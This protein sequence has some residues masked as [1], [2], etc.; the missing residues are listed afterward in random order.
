MHLSRGENNMIDLKLV[1]P[2]KEYQIEYLDMIEE[3]KATGEKMVPF[4]LRFDSTDFDVFLQEI[5]HQKEGQL[6]NE[7]LA[8]ST[9]YWLVNSDRRV[10]GAV[11]IRHH[12]T[13]SLLEIGGHI[14][15]GIRPSERKKGYATKILS[16]ALLKAKEL[17]IDRALLTCDKANIGSAKTMIY[18]GGVL[19][20]EA[21]VNGVEIQ[22]YWID[23]K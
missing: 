22:R 12:L 11:N 1:E 3:W 21:V 9:S 19:D 10:L 23:I 6:E 8:N 14:G 4:T 18:N 17:D 16:L 20:S 5:R 15:Y 2:N 13:P 7:N